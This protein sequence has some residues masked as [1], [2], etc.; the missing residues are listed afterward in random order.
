[1]TTQNEIKEIKRLIKVNNKML[2]IDP[3]CSQ[4]NKFLRNC[5]RINE[6]LNGKKYNVAIN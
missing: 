4:S 2:S 5:E 1:M 6:L 3:S